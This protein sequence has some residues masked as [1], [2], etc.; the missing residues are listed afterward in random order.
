MYTLPNFIFIDICT[1][2]RSSLID[3][4]L[5]LDIAAICVV[6]P[7]ECVVSFTADVV[8]AKSFYLSL[9]QTFRAFPLAKFSS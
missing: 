1:L 4:I 9:W 2:S 7:G 6:A 3:V 5:V 8:A